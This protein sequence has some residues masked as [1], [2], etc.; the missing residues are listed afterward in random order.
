MRNNGDVNRG[1]MVQEV[2]TG[3]VVVFLE[4]VGDNHKS[5]IVN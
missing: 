1:P 2:A 4:V 5:R 3:G